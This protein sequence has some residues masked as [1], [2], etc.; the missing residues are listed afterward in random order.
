MTLYPGFA[1]TVTAL[2]FNFMGDTLRDALDPKIRRRARM[3]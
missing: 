3:A 1:V 2:T